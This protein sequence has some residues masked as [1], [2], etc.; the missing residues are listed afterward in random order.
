[1]KKDYVDVIYDENKTP[2]T[3]YPQKLANYLVNRFGMQRGENLLDVGCGR[4]EF[5]SGFINLG[6]DGHGLDQSMYAKTYKKINNIEVINLE[7]EPFPYPDNKFDY[8]F[9]KS[10]IEHFYYPEKIMSEIY[11]VL[12]PG[13]LVITMC[14]SWEFNY[15]IYFEDYTHRTPFM[16]SSLQDLKLIAGFRDVESEYFRQLPIVWRFPWV[17]YFCDFVRFVAPSQLS[18]NSKFIRFSKEIMLL[19]SGRK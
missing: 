17:K 9:S 6:L 14:P 11:R 1:M 5:L 13:G 19:A 4:G 10:V 3:N 16:K 12:K 8:V 2:F 7:R 15:R 18:K